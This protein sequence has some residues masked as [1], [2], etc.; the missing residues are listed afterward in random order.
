MFPATQ[1]DPVYGAIGEFRKRLL[2]RGIRL[3]YFSEWKSFNVKTLEDVENYLPVLFVI[4]GET[5]IFSPERILEFV[6]KGC[7]L[8]MPYTSLGLHDSYNQ[9]R[10]NM[11][12]ALGLSQD[13]IARNA[14]DEKIIQHGFGK[15]IFINTDPIADVHFDV[16]P[17]NQPTEQETQEATLRIASIIDK[18]ALFNVPCVDANIKSY[19]SSWPVDNEMVIE[20][21]V[22]NLSDFL[23]SSV[24]VDID[25]ADGLEPLSN[26]LIK[27]NLQS[28]ETRTLPVVVVPRNKG[29]MNNPITI[30]ITYEGRTRKVYL[31]PSNINILDNL[32]SQLRSSKPLAVDLT[33]ELPRFEEYL[34]PIVS[35]A[36]IASLLDVDPGSVVQKARQIG[37]SICIS[38]AS[39]HVRNYKKDWDFSTIT[40]RLYENKLISSKAKGYI[41]TIRILGNLASHPSGNSFEQSDAVMICHALVLF[42]SEASDNNLL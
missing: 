20:L 7:N 30:A 35:S 9:S 32:H 10:L 18:I 13:E 37:E 22:N 21:E 41:D 2:N 42:L 4:S 12:T 19:P 26:L 14:M 31:N 3:A 16:G 23:L 8:L 27:T 11:F 24:I 17:M 6:N 1:D 36:T 15:I 28:Q 38:I 39:K 29:L 25:V 5:K 40:R 33:T 34:K